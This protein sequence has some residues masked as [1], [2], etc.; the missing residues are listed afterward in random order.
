MYSLYERRSDREDRFIGDY[1]S[2]GL[3]QEVT[4]VRVEQLKELGDTGAMFYCK[5]KGEDDISVGW[6]YRWAED[7]DKCN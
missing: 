5:V 7:T 4:E 2:L 6:I 3:C 1:D